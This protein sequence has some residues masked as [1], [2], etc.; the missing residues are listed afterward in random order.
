M[1]VCLLSGPD[2]VPGQLLRVGAPWLANP[3]VRLFSLS[4]NQGYLPDDWTSANVTPVFKKGNK[5]L[6]INYRPVS[7]TCTVVKLLER[8][9]H[10]QLSAFLESN[11]K[12]T[13]FQHGF[14][15]KHSCQTQ[16]LESVHQWARCLDRARSS[17]VV[18]TDLSKAFDTCLKL[19]HIGIRAKLLTWIGSFLLNR[20]QRV[21]IDGTSSEWS[22][23]TSGVPQGSILYRSS[24]I[25][26][27]Y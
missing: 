26:Y 3:L 1:K 6:V 11:N 9:V 5:H 16:L 14:R 18:F 15:K 22:D 23:V 2:D 13:P 12:L 25:H 17:H 19:E 8:L 27:L 7:F 4:L 10:N 20:R 24:T 21:L